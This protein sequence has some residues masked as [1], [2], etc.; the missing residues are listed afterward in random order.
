MLTSYLARYLYLPFPYFPNS[1]MGKPLF[2]V[3]FKHEGEN[4]YVP[5]C[6]RFLLIYL[7]INFCLFFV[8]HVLKKKKTNFKKVIVLMITNV[9][10]GNAKSKGLKGRRWH[11]LS[12]KNL[13]LQLRGTASKN[14]GSLCCLNCLPSFRTKNRL[15]SQKRVM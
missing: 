4:K 3:F 10:K 1:I 15:E 11:Y 7:F 2:G 5:I 6:F 12:V 13:S 14:N 9:E 8:Y